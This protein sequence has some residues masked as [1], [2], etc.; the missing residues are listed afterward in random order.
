MDFCEFFAFLFLI[1]NGSIFKLASAQYSIDSII[2]SSK[3]SFG[4]SFTYITTTVGR[5]T[6]NTDKNIIRLVTSLNITLPGSTLVILTSPYTTYDPNLFLQYDV[7][8]I[9]DYVNYDITPEQFSEQNGGRY[10]FSN[11]F[12]VYRYKF[13]V[14]YL[15]KHPELDLVMFF[16]EDTVILKDPIDL[17]A[18]DT[19]PN[20]IHMM[21]D[22]FDYTARWDN[23]YRW[24]NAWDVNL[25]CNQTKRDQCH[26]RHLVNPMNSTALGK[27]YPFN[28]GLMFG[29]A[30][31]VL[32]LTRVLAKTSLC[33][34]LFPGITEQGLINYL[35]YNGEI[36]ANG[37]NIYGHHMN[38]K[39][40]ISC[41]EHLSVQATKC[42]ESWYILHHIF[43]A[44][45]S[46]YTSP[47]IQMLKEIK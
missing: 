13:Y 30:E 25:N 3:L 32:E 15:E 10:P 22:Y 9:I 46:R 38:E 4:R 14:D 7:N 26:V 28:A 29:R 6:I 8:I 39:L 12:Y 34:N 23:N 20:T 31:S 21:Y 24:L 42:Y 5:P 40:I 43:H 27:D 2:W 16:D 44:R 35:Y 11:W 45:Y 41:A 37:I 33:V 36:S 17:I 47:L 18:N 19:D 1:V